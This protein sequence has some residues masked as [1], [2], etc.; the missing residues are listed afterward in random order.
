MKTMT[1]C[2]FSRPEFAVRVRAHVGFAE[3][4]EAAVSWRW[5]PSPMSNGG[6]VYGN[7]VGSSV[8]LA[9]ASNRFCSTGSYLL[10]AYSSCTVT[11]GGFFGN[12]GW[13]IGRESLM[14]RVVRAPRI[15]RFCN[16]SPSCGESWAWA[17]SFC[18]SAGTMPSLKSMKSIKRR[19]RSGG[20]TPPSSSVAMTCAATPLGFLY[21]SSRPVARIC[22]QR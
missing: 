21:S 9:C 22:V 7:T 17:I 12:S 5:S 15:S 19:R 11:G 16:T 18:R 2:R 20:T 6:F 14:F 1:R 4:S 8:L 13:G 10:S 3:R